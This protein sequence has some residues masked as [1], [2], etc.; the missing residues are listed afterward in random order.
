M[1]QQYNYRRDYEYGTAAR[2][3]AYYPE[4][5]ETPDFDTR[6]VRRARR[7]NVSVLGL[8]ITATA[9]ALFVSAMVNYVQLQ[10]ALTSKVKTVANKQIA[11]NNL[12]SSNDE[13]YSRIASSVDLSQIE[14]VARTELGMTYASEG[15]VV[16]YTSAGHDYMR[17]VD[18]NN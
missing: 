18:S 15:Q 8:L 6:P 4:R 5:R 12:E 17:K 3:Y 2:N 11:L 13:M 7:T 9:F 10:G 16:V 14:T 1:A